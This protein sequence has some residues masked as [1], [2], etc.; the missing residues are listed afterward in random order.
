MHPTLTSFFDR[1]SHIS[2]VKLVVISCVVHQ[3][4]FAFKSSLSFSVGQ[5]Q[6][7]GLIFLSSMA[8]SL[9]ST[10]L[11]YPICHD[12]HSPDC[13][14]AVV[15]TVLVGLSLATALLGLA[16]IVTG[17][18]RLTSFVQYLPLPVI[19]GYLAFIGL[20]CLEAGLS[21]M[22]GL[23]ITGLQAWGQLADMTLL[24]YYLPASPLS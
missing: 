11:A 21:M 2:Q 15:V 16:L 12:P 23:Q 24:S 14:P 1:T 22:T 7:A 13:A 8:S 6:D 10:V 19:G 3:T 20:Y 5:V 4:C 18:L 9:V 17:R